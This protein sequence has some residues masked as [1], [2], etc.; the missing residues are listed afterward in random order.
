MRPNLMLWLNISLRDKVL[1]VI[2][3]PINYCT[4]LIKR[5]NILLFPMEVLKCEEITWKL[6]YSK[7]RNNLILVAPI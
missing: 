3:L 4:H 7:E 6:R 2:R 1:I 5:A